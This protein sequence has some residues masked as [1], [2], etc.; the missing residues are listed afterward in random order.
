MHVLSA[1]E[2]T[3]YFQTCLSQGYSDLH[4]VGRLMIRQGCRPGELLALRSQDVHLETMSATLRIRSGKTDAARRSLWLASESRHLLAG[5]ALS[6]S[7]WVFPSRR[8]PDLPISRLDGP[9]GRVLKQMGYGEGEGFVVYD[10][11]HTFATQAALGGMDLPTL[12]AIL[13]HSNIRSVMRYVHVSQAH[14]NEAMERLDVQ[15]M[16]AGSEAEACGVVQ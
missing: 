11:R 14:Q 12:A 2:E 16:G 3:V 1:K 4:D 9:H 7:L 10:L 15:H 13:G 8:H 5:R 6:S